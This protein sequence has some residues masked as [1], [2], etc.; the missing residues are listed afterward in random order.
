MKNTV[1][2]CLSTLSFKEMRLQGSMVFCVYW[3]SGYGDRHQCKKPSLVLSV[4]LVLH[5]AECAHAYFYGS[6]YSS[7]KMKPG[8]APH[9]LHK[10]TF[11]NETNTTHF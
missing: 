9:F 11:P 1:K 10:A 5:G 7:M 6:G 3:D 2:P 4:T 8:S